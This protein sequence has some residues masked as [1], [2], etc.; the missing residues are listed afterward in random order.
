MSEP[1]RLCVITARRQLMKTN[2]EHRFNRPGRIPAG[3][4]GLF[5]LACLLLLLAGSIR[6]LPA[7]SVRTITVQPSYCP[8]DTV[9]VGGQGWVGGETVTIDFQPS[10]DI[11]H[12]TADS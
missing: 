10:G 6:S 1:C 2:I 4:N 8:G 9:R 5:H 3:L 12:A 11:F 7:G